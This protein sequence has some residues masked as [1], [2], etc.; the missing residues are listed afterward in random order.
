M[1]V[2]VLLALLSIAAPVLLGI[3]SS[4]AG[5][6]AGILLLVIAAV[7]LVG[8]L[9]AAAGIGAVAL[10][11][12][13][14]VMLFTEPWGGVLLA[15]CGILLLGLALLGAALS[16]LVYGRMLPFCIRSVIDWISGLFHRGRRTRP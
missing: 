8:F 16:I 14:V 4:A 10:L 1:R 15:G 13:G 12:T 2:V 3:G 5:I 9:T 6:A 11:V 7:A